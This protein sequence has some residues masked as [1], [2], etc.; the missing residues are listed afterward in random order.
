M[1]PTLRTFIVTLLIALAAAIPAAAQNSLDKIIEPLKD[2]ENGSSVMYREKRTPDTHALVES[3][4]YIEFSETKLANKIIEAMKKERQNAVSYSAYEDKRNKNYKIEFSNKDGYKAEY[5]LY[6]INSK[7]TLNVK[8]NYPSAS[9]P[10]SS[11]TQSSSKNNKKT[12]SRTSTRR[13]SNNRR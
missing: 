11:S 8:T 2:G 5:S 7:Y 6:Y 12:S 4:L 1:N 13:S 9:K 3:A 10:K